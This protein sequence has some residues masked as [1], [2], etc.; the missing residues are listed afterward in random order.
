MEARRGKLSVPG[1]RERAH[2]WLSD[3]V[4]ETR[5]ET[6]GFRYLRNKAFHPQ[7]EGSPCFVG[8][9]DCRFGR[10]DLTCIPRT[11]AFTVLITHSPDAVAEA[12]PQFVGHLVLAGHTHGGQIRF[13]GIGPLFT[14]SAY[15]RT[16]DMGWYKRRSDG[17]RMYITTGT[18]TAG[19]GLL[20][21]RMLCPPEVVAIDLM[22]E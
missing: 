2:T 20:R 17:T 22:S 19:S 8:L 18:G 11:D 5:Y 21:R 9:D 3:D 4:W 12:G 14:S 6:A 10:V 7:P 13:P 16:F 1:N 15:W